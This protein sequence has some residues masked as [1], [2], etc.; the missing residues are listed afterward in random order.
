M[1]NPDW[2]WPTLQTDTSP[3]VNFQEKANQ[4]RESIDKSPNSPTIIL[5]EVRRLYDQEQQRRALVDS[6]AGVYQASSAAFVAVLLSITPLFIDK[7]DEISS[8][9]QGVMYCFSLSFLVMAMVL[10]AR[11]LRWSHKALAVSVT[12]VLDWEALTSE[13]QCKDCFERSIAKKLLV[14]QH[15]NSILTNDV[16]TDIKMV[17]ALVT[18]AFFWFILSASFRVILYLSS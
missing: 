4:I 12:H 9:S 1:I 18:A 16:V 8:I 17:Q 11:A 15:K 14:Y 13:Q 3:G 7:F 5:D 10:L 6:K 2:F